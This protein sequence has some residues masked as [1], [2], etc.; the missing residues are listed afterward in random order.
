MLSFFLCLPYYLYEAFWLTHVPV[1]LSMALWAT[2]SLLME[3]EYRS[4][5]SKSSKTLDNWKK[6]IVSAAV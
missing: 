1:Q 2:L 6:K 3:S 4:Y 5:L